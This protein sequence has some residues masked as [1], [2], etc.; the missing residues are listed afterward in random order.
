MLVA[1]LSVSLLL[2]APGVTP[3]YSTDALRELVASASATNAR[4]PAMLAS[5]TATVETEAALIGVDQRSREQ[6]ILLEQVARAVT[7]DR[8]GADEQRAVAYRSAGSVMTGAT[9][10]R[11][12][13]WIVPVL[14][15]NR[16]GLLFGPAPASSRSRKP[17]DK[18]PRRVESI[19]PLSARRD[20]IYRF[21]LGDT[22]AV[23][24]PGAR[25]IPVVRIRVE[26]AAVP[27]VATTVL[28][29]ELMVDAATHQ[30]ISLRGE[31]LEVGGTRSLASRVRG[32]LYEAVGYLDLQSREIDGR[33]WLPG[34]QRIE[35]QIA[36]PLAGDARAVWRFQTRFDDIAVATNDSATTAA[37]GGDTLAA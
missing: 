22:I 13:S 34:T 17:D 26:P 28:R 16:F 36:S 37:G 35:L 11:L 6:T 21:T 8:S 12:P 32:S 27:A 9:V 33:Y 31:I 25:D 19:H 18:P 7:W 20:E 23:I 2:Q 3:G 15:G 29:G 4:V 24:R 14:Y 30:L 5:Y 10:L 1:A